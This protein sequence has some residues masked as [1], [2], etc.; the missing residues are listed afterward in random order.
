M[1]EVEE[2]TLHRPD[3]LQRAID[4]MSQ[5]QASPFDRR[6]LIGATLDALDRGDLG[7]ALL[8]IDLARTHTLTGK[9]DADAAAALIR[10]AFDLD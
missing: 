3:A 1:N 9:K 5:V 8:S 2:V 6:P 10:R 7:T 4:L